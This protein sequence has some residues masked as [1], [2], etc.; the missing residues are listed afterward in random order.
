MKNDKC[1]FCK[2]ITEIT[3]KKKEQEI[4]KEIKE[5]LKN[6]VIQG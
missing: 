5:S 6:L 3:R 4:K 2:W 1:S